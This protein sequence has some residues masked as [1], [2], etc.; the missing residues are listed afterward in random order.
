MRDS[1]ARGEF[2]IQ[3]GIQDSVYGSEYRMPHSAFRI[4]S[5]SLWALGSGLKID[6][7]S[8]VHEHHS[9]SLA[10][11]GYK[12]IRRTLGPSV[13]EL[14]RSGKI[15]QTLMD[16]ARIQRKQRDYY[17]RAGEIAIQLAQQGKIQDINLDRILAKI[18]RS[19]RLLGRQDILVRSYQK[20]G[21]IREMLRAE[22]APEAPSETEAELMT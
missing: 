1:V 4:L 17:R 19:E 20:R 3:S 16:S 7:M 6:S 8:K 12:W 5:F 14:F 9:R 21:D 11:R 13:R 2:G 15:F 10:W 18:Q 22:K